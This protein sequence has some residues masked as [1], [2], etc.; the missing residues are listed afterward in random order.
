MQPLTFEQL[1]QAETW[2]KRN[3]LFT[4]Y[5]ETGPLRREL[6]P[7]HM[8]F[9]EKGA[10]VQQ[11]LAISG[12]RCITPWTPVEM[13]SSTR[14]CG[15]L[16]GE[17]SFCVRSWDG[18]SRCTS[19]A[20]GLFLKGIEQAFRIHLDN[21]Q[22]F[23]CTRKHQVLTT[24]GWIG[25]DWIVRSAGGLHL[26]QTTS[27]SM[28]S[29]AAGDCPHGG[30]PPSQSDND[31]SQLPSPERALRQ[32]PSSSHV[33]E[34]V[35]K[36]LRNRASQYSSR[37]PIQD[38]PSLLAAL[39]GL[40]EDP[41]SYRHTQPHDG[42]IREAFEFLSG[43][44]R[45]R[46]AGGP[47]REYLRGY[48]SAFSLAGLQLNVAAD[49]PRRG[50]ELLQTSQQF[51]ICSVPAGSGLEILG[52]GGQVEIF[53]P[54]GNV[55]PLIGGNSIKYIVPLGCQPILD[56]T[57]ENTHCYESGGVIHHNTGKTSGL[58]A[59][60]TSLHLTGLYPDWWKGRR[61]KRPI[62]SWLVG[63]TSETTRDILQVEMI[64]PVERASGSTEKVGIG[65]GMI[66]AHL[67][68]SHAPKA[69]VPGALDSVW[70]K[71]VSGGT[72]SLGF[73]SYGSGSGG[74]RDSFE[75]V[76]RD[77]IGLDE[78]PPQ[79]VVDECLMRLMSTNPDEES[80]SMIITFTPMEGYTQVV[81]S[82]LETD[83]PNKWYCQIGWKHVPHLTADVIKFMSANYL[84]SQ[85][86]A[87]S[88]GVP[89][90]GEGAIYPIDID[91]I[92]EDAF[93]IPAHWPRAFGMDVGKTAVV[94]GALDIDA[95][96]LHLTDEYFS[97]DYNPILHANAIKARGEWIPGVIDPSSLQSN[98][99]DGQK[100]YDIYRKLGLDIE[101]QKTAVEAG[102][103]E[104][105]MRLS[106]GRLKVFRHLQKFRNEFER[107]HRVK[108]ETVFGVQDKIVKKDDHCLD[109]TRYLITSGMRRMKCGPVSKQQERQDAYTRNFQAGN[110]FS[111]GNGAWMG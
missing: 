105:W 79:P 48:W 83:N 63:K 58:L 70:V 32:P 94:W 41:A 15:E 90:I 2:R 104:V 110:L 97:T 1:D 50:L 88:E 31:Q 69:G 33:D 12:N 10:T 74:Q 76:K 95:D 64:G 17:T 99:M 54:Y 42:L 44:S 66:P 56:F 109:A 19:E 67:I 36:L 45:T 51:H 8:E 13:D 40:W 21:G 87:R 85:L 43:F 89:A 55:F 9:F 72:S 103:Q 49:K 4:Y 3:K 71:H 60:E 16:I 6:Y 34:A 86:K 106:T 78:E 27:N 108:S 62:S 102:I 47:I 26:I 73:K 68:I 5:P 20:S 98:Q 81:K 80:G 28:A 29:Y 53:A 24:S 111:G 38:D 77:W 59:Y 46:S 39:C 91:E 7:R 11:R 92:T 65:L 18:G 57:V 101:W 22:F 96:V 84:P 100:L 75:G 52:D 82:F 23:D 93:P 61:F 14:R 37:R 25:V 107:Y 30:Q 35:H